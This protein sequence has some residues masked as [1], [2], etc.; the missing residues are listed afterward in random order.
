MACN[1]GNNLIGEAGSSASDGCHWSQ[2]CGGCEACMPTAF[3]FT[4]ESDEAQSDQ[5]TCCCASNKVIATGN[6]GTYGAQ[7]GCGSAT[8]YVNLSIRKI[9]PTDGEECENIEPCLWEWNSA[10]AQWEFTPS[11]RIGATTPEEHCQEDVDFA[12]T[13]VCQEPDFAGLRNGQQVTTKCKAYDEEGEYTECA[14]ILDVSVLDCYGTWESDQ[15]K[16]QPYEAGSGLGG[17]IEISGG[18]IS[19]TLSW[20]PLATTPN[21]KYRKKCAPCR[22]PYG[23]LA[24]NEN[25]VP[26]HCT[27]LPYE[28][29]FKIIY[30]DS[31]DYRVTPI[32]AT[33]DP[34]DFSYSGTGTDKE[35]GALITV[36]V[37][38][39]GVAESSC[40]PNSAGEYDT[41]DLSEDCS[42]LV[43]IT[44]DDDICFKQVYSLLGGPDVNQSRLCDISGEEIIGE[45]TD[46]LTLLPESVTA[47]WAGQCDLCDHKDAECFGGCESLRQIVNPQCNPRVLTGTIIAPGCIDLDGVSWEMYEPGQTGPDECSAVTGGPANAC[48]EY[49]GGPTGDNGPICDDGDPINWCFV[50]Y[51]DPL[52][53]D[54]DEP[55]I[56]RYRLRYT[57]LATCLGDADSGPHEVSVDVAT[58]TCDPLQLD[59]TIAAPVGV[60]NEFVYDPCVCCGGADITVRITE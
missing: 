39:C 20:E 14:L 23:P 12:C 5:P 47:T 9:D 26:S 40:Y 55:V 31:C 15:Y 41:V 19:G 60:A 44:S 6:C 24:E 58:S 59:F 53:C 42:Y 11:S 49:K 48:Q 16:V 1:T 29:C 52:A 50:L 56:G 46:P 27:C 25:E 36:L 8:I 10:L 34:S 13:S 51:Y 33:F 32:L 28:L 38:L 57:F 4:F 22:D 18:Q 17:S 35:T 3:C 37:Q 30:N 2:G 54:P 21:P 45:S 7:I 43:S